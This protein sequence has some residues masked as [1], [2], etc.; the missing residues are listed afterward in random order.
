MIKCLQMILKDFLSFK[1]P[2][3]FNVFYAHLIYYMDLNIHILI[4]ID[5]L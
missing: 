3:F 2:I 1:P 4:Q 5:E